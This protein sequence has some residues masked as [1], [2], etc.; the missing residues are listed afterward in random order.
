MFGPRSAAGRWVEVHPHSED[1]RSKSADKV[2]FTL[3]PGIMI[4]VV[5][6]S[7]ATLPMGG[8]HQMSRSVNVSGATDPVARAKEVASNE[9]SR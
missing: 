8:W 5:I 4:A 9:R 7:I 3:A 2:L 6:V 1:Y